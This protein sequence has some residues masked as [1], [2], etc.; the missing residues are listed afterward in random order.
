MKRN[1]KKNLT[2]VNLSNKRISTEKLVYP[3]DETTCLQLMKNSQKSFLF[4][5]HS[6]SLQYRINTPEKVY[7]RLSLYNFSG[8]LK[9]VLSDRMQSNKQQ[10]SL[11]EKNGGTLN[12]NNFLFIQHLKIGPKR[13]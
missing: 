7:R 1:N 10:C 13:S 5:I 4:Q 12:E 6:I 9:T 2:L 3:I 11:E 8:N